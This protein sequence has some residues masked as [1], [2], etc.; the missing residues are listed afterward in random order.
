[1][2]QSGSNW[3]HFVLSF[4]G[5]QSNLKMSGSSEGLVFIRKQCSF[6]LFVLGDTGYGSDHLQ[7]RQDI[8]CL[9]TEEYQ[10]FHVQSTL[11]AV[12]AGEIGV[13]VGVNYID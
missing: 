6:V 5:I 10:V 7:L 13:D 3:R 2:T 1:M 4:K 9:K 12:M 11:Q 8:S